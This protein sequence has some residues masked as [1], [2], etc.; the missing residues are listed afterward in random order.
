[1]L[2]FQIDSSSGI[3][4][5]RQVMDQ[6]RSYASAGMLEPGQQLPS[7][8]GLAKQLAVNPSTIVKAYSELEHQG[9]IVLRKGRGAFLSDTP[10]V[11][12]AAEKNRR[13]EE[14]ATRFLA[15]A[16]RLGADAETI[17]ATFER[18]L[19]GKPPS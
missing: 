18:L 7:I 3:P 9:V 8:R 4:V 5:Y 6:V 16:H 11:L 17:R 14:L 19:D 1:M 13:L 10:P 15:E 2:H 12:P